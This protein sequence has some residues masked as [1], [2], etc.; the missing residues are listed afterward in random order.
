MW[1]GYV[2]IYLYFNILINYSC[3]L[4]VCNVLVLILYI[5]NYLLMV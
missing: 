5:C 3:Q 1:F 4:L 2:G